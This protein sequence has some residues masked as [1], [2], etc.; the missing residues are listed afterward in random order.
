MDGH[1]ADRIFVGVGHG[2]PKLQV[3]VRLYGNWIIESPGDPKAASY[4]KRP[5]VAVP[6]VT[7]IWTVAVLTGLAAL[8]FWGI[9]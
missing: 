7:V 6:D 9:R 3:S 8:L 1:E 4:S 5:S 2:P